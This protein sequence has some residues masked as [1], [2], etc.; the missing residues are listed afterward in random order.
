MFNTLISVYYNHIIICN[1]RKS[2][3]KICILFPISHLTHKKYTSSIS[4]CKRHR[5]PASLF[6]RSANKANPTTVL[7]S[8]LNRFIHTESEED[9]ENSKRERERDTHTHCK[10]RKPEIRNPYNG[11]RDAIGSDK[12][13]ADLAPQRCQPLLVRPRGPSR[14]PQAPFRRRNCR[15]AR[16]FAALPS[17]QE[18]QRQAPPRGAVLHLRLLRRQ[19][20]QRPPSR[21]HQV[22]EH[23]RVQMAPRIPSARWIGNLNLINSE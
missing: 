3:Y 20:L 23:L 19:S 4:L 14:S 11:V 22:Q 15:E 1:L 18:L 9:E 13:V 6:F 8:S 16:S 21:A 5:L 17:V 7:V 12:A 10:S 2:Y